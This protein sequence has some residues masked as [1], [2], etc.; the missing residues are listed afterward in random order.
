MMSPS[1]SSFL[2]A[3]STARTVL[4]VDKHLARMA[5]ARL[6]ANPPSRAKAPVA[7]ARRVLAK[8]STPV[9]F[10]VD[11]DVGSTG[12]LETGASN[13]KSCL[14]SGSRIGSKGASVHWKESNK[15]TSEVRYFAV[16]R[17]P[18]KDEGYYSNR[19][20]IPG[21]VWYWT[22]GPKCYQTRQE[23]T[24]LA[25]S[26][27]GTWDADG[28]G[29]PLPKGCV[30]CRQLASSGAW[31]PDYSDFPG[32]GCNQDVYDWCSREARKLLCEEC[33]EWN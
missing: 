22:S 24:Y 15:T 3:S 20:H 27:I 16:P 28:D 33:E 30:Y 14:K 26:R 19:P 25:P 8:V 12:P 23:G 7:A 6:A 4:S 31:I 1:S 5:K 13:L 11:S 10:V 32:E 9:V 17:T 18:P 21:A 2:P 29:P